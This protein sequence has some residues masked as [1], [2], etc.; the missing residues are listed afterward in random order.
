MFRTIQI[1]LIVLG[2]LLALGGDRLSM[3]MLTYAG[4]ACFGLLAMAI[5]W[6]AIVTRQIQLGRRRSGN[7]ETYTGFPA[8]L[9]GIQFNLIGL[10]LIGLSAFIYLNDGNSGRE[11]FL[12]FVRRPGIPLVLIGLLI[13]LQALV[14]FLGYRE[15]SEGPGWMVKINLLFSRMMPGV[16]LLV[17]GLGVIGLGLLEIIAPVVFDAMGGG[18]LETLYSV[19]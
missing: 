2:I 14:M 3:P 12:Q 18:F 17:L 11:I 9:Q 10:F 19:R 8:I 6:E 1:V 13:L 15:I 4:I 5:G 7:L 16:I